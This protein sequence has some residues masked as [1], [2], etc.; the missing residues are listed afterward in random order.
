MLNQKNLEIRKFQKDTN[1]DKL[2]LSYKLSINNYRKEH[3]S[4][5]WNNF[6]KEKF[7]NIQ[8]KD[9]HNFRNNNLSVGM[10]N[11]RLNQPLNEL[12]FNLTRFFF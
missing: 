8:I 4:V 5:H 3:K 1:I 11:V 9:L 12:R 2:K 10:D 6:L 7:L